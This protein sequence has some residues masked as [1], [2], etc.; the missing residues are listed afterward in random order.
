[1]SFLEIMGSIAAILVAA[2]TTVH[3]W[4]DKSKIELF[5]SSSLSLMPD[6]EK[7]FCT[8]KLE[9]VNHGRRVA[10]IAE[11]HIESKV[12]RISLFQ[13][14]DPRPVVLS[15]GDR[16]EFIFSV[17]KKDYGWLIAPLKKKEEYSV[18]LTTGKV[19]KTFCMIPK[20]PTPK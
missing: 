13:E 11:A 17:E 18:K 6:T 5:G 1:M 19:F 9:V 12:H 3:F 10:Q 8:F 14:G 7:G 4:K 16:H 15:E 2:A 20:I